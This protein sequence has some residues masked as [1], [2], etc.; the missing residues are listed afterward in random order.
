MAR[1]DEFVAFAQEAAPGLYRRALMLTNDHHS[2]EDLV[3][4]TLAR[5]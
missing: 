2:A 1:S 5:M 3:Q 4:E